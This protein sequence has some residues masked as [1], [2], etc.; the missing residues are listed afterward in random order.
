MS[1]IKPYL[2]KKI[3][4]MGKNKPKSLNLS[5]NELEKIHNEMPEA[6]GDEIT[7]GGVK[8]KGL[9]DEAKKAKKKAA[10]KK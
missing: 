8:I 2:E 4:E 1:K 3:K 7:I 9:S 10:K 5:Q 6:K